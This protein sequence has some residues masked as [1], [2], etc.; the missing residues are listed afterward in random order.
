MPLFGIRPNDDDFL[1]SHLGDKGAYSNHVSRFGLPLPSTSSTGLF[2]DDAQALAFRLPILDSQ[3]G[4]ATLFED[5]ILNNVVLKQKQEQQRAAKVHERHALEVE[6][7]EVDN[8]LLEK[9]QSTP[10]PSTHRDIW[11]QAVSNEVHKTAP[12]LS[13]WD[14]LDRS[15]KS[16]ASP[17]F[18]EA[19]ARVWEAELSL[20]SE[21]TSRAPAYAHAVILDNLMT[22]VRGLDSVLFAWDTEKERYVWRAELKGKARSGLENRGRF[23]GISL[24]ASHSYIQRFF[25]LASSMSRLDEV[26]R[27][28]VEPSSSPST[29][30]HAVSS[31]LSAFIDWA[32]EEVV[33]L[34]PTQLEDPSDPSSRDGLAV[35]WARLAD[36]ARVVESVSTIFERQYRMVP[37][38]APMPRTTASLLSL[39]HDNLKHHLAYS[40][41]SPLLEQTTSAWLLDHALSAWWTGWEAWVGI[42]ESSHHESEHTWADLGIEVE[43]TRRDLSMLQVR[44]AGSGMEELS[45]TRYRLHLSRIPTFFPRNVAI[46]LFE[47]GRALRLLRRAKPDHPL[48]RPQRIQNAGRG[49]RWDVGDDDSFFQ[50]VRTRVA[51]LRNDVRAWQV[52][53]YAPDVLPDNAFLVK[54]DVHTSASSLKYPAELAD[55]FGRFTTL[56]VTNA[57]TA[58]HWSTDTGISSFFADR[59]ESP[60]FSILPPSIPNLDILLSTSLYRPLSIF[61]HLPSAAFLTLFFTDLALT[62]HLDVLHSFLLFGDAPF[63]QRFRDALF[64]PPE[65]REGSSIQRRR[66]R[67]V[68]VWGA[69]DQ[70]ELGAE[71]E[72]W[73]IGIGIRGMTDQT[74]WPPGGAELALALRAALAESI[75]G[76]IESVD[77]KMEDPQTNKDKAQLNDTQVWHSVDS[78]LSFAYRHDEVEM[79]PNSLTAFN[80]LY[81]DYKAPS[82]LDLVI[83][84]SVQGKYQQIFT[85]LLKL[86]RIEA[87]MRNLTLDITKPVVFGLSRNGRL[88]DKTKEVPVPSLLLDVDPFD[89]RARK[90]LIALCFELRTLVNSITGH[91]YHSAIDANVSRFKKS[92]QR[93]ERALHQQLHQGKMRP[94]DEEEDDDPDSASVW[95]LET[96]ELVHQQFLD[97]ILLSL[98]LQKRQRP[99]MRVVTEGIFQVVLDLGRAVKKWKKFQASGTWPARAEQTILEEIM[100]MH[101]V[102]TSQASTLVKV[103]QALDDRGSS[104]KASST[105]G[106]SS[107]LKDQRGKKLLEEM[108]AGFEAKSAGYLSEWVFALDAN[109]FYAGL[110]VV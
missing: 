37:P 27:S 96:L 85:H 23:V 3:S 16:Y 98:L 107:S 10:G 46:E 62:S 110:G 67:D 1:V 41:T 39:L 47:A 89:F 82:P 95:N 43:I 90:A 48:S 25:F 65:E 74:S 36:L 80:F 57:L 19:S 100:G 55:L 29:I 61:G 75:Q 66:A 77:R 71:R 2:K 78:R 88:D 91:A 15:D 68:N 52:G 6:R 109:R 76:R 63:V 51:Q 49:I 73:G 9:E 28:L 72:G 12:Q 4:T 14:N 18:S 87:V 54:L 105:T 33:R 38:L 101:R 59:I 45:R 24:E 83:I 92:L 13:T 104:A 64:A 50:A 32:R 5:V 11:S 99:L 17:F 53:K 102:L 94:T 86:M 93:I 70:G 8:L 84:P 42:A 60:T 26:A 58:P 35:V 20:N 81:L 7:Q 103:L 31:S 56:P 22:I 21:R 108:E 69:K 44:N 34:C 97:R 40:L 79:D 30:A 106:S